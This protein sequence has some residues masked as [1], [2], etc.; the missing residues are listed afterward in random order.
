MIGW[1]DT[2]ALLF[3]FDN[4]CPIGSKGLSH[5]LQTNYTISFCFCLYLMLYACATR[6]DVTW[7]FFKKIEF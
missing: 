2:V 7:N 5:K 6:F 1:L 4:Y 3:V